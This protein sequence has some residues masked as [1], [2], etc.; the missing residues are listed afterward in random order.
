MKKFSKTLVQSKRSERECTAVFVSFPGNPRSFDR[1]SRGFFEYTQFVYVYVLCLL[2][3][4][5]GI[6]PKYSNVFLSLLLGLV[7]FYILFADKSCTL[8]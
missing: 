2:V 3:L 1:F 4:S 8:K 5:M 6:F 7:L